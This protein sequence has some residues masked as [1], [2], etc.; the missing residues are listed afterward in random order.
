MQTIILMLD[1][2]GHNVYAIGFGD[3]FHEGVVPPI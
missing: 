3:G 1:D 2:L